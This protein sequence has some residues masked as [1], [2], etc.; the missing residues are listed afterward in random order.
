MDYRR[1]GQIEEMPMSQAD[2]DAFRLAQYLRNQQ[3]QQAQT[4][5]QTGL[6]KTAGQLGGLYLGSKAAGLTSS[7]P[8]VP[9]GLSLAPTT[10]AGIATPTGLTLTPTAAPTVMG[11]LGSLGVGPLAAIAGAT[12]LGGKAGYDMLQ[13]KK[14]D[15]PGRVVL[16]MATGGISEIAN[17]LLNR[18]STRDIAKS[19]TKDLLSQGKD[20]PAWQNYVQG[21]RAQYAKAPTGP[22]FAGKYNSWDEY[23]RAGLEAADLTGVRG[24]L[25]TFGPGYESLG[26]DR[27]KQITQALIDA[28]LY[29]SKKGEVNITDAAKALALRDQILKTAL[30]AQSAVTAPVN[31]GSSAPIITFKEGIGGTKIPVFA[32]SP[33]TLA[34][35][36]AI[37]AEKKK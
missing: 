30:P 18:K 26:F 12:A 15:V 28:N 22:A 17:A 16:G 29:E 8:A 13:G 10:S 31:L 1:A 21:M 3:A 9:T 11:N 6:G 35:Y 33:A 14:A 25:K 32:P 2:I 4:D 19:H 24:N 27:Q 37:N 20:N 5:P 7:A 23:K 34:K 36:E